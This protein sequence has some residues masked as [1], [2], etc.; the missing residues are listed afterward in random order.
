MLH[1]LH[2]HTTHTAHTTHTT[3]TTHIIQGIGFQPKN[4]AYKIKGAAACNTYTFCGNT[5]NLNLTRAR[6]SVAIEPTGVDQ[7]SL[8]S[9]GLGLLFVGD[10]GQTFN[11]SCIVHWAYT[12][13]TMYFYP[14]MNGNNASL[15]YGAL[16]AQFNGKFPVGTSLTVLKPGTK[17]DGVAAVQNLMLFSTELWTTTINKITTEVRKVP[18]AVISQV[19]LSL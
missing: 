8:C 7:S 2:T 18:P 5:S 14:T 3:H 11:F 15:N 10:N 12:N 16:L 6:W 17:A 13:T 9:E 19:P 4:I 1:M